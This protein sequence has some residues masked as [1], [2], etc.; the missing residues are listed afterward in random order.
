MTDRPKNFGLV[1]VAGFVAPRHLKAIRDTGNRIVAVTDPKDAVGVLDQYSFD[2]KYFPEIERFDRHLERLQRSSSD[3]QIDYLSV[4]SPNY[5][6]DAH[7]RLGLRVGAHVICEKPLVINPW[8]LDLLQEIEAESGKRI[9]TVL[10]L[11]QHERLQKLKAEVE[12]DKSGRRYDVVLTYITARGP[13]YHYSWKGDET[14]AGGVGMNIGVHF[15]DMLQWIYGKVLSFEL[16]LHDSERMA[17]LLELERA[18]VRWFLSVA[19]SDLPHNPNQKG[20]STFREIIA[21]D[22]AVE[23]TDGFSDLH[24]RVYEDVLSGRGTGIDE[25]RPAIELV[26]N[27]RHA[28]PS[29]AGEGVHPFVRRASKV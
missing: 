2:V 12:A 5:L 10:Q 23:F 27:L 15:F 11:R 29:V 7:I 16:H 19:K 14:K 25:A 21:D 26:Y 1:G 4:C 6:H 17:G 3:Q 28:S 18:R 24:T 9:Y 13:W 8:N 20:A 22:Q